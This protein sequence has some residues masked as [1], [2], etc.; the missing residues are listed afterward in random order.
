MYFHRGDHISTQ[1]FHDNECHRDF[2]HVHGLKDGM[3]LFSDAPYF[4]TKDNG[5]MTTIDR[6]FEQLYLFDSSNVLVASFELEF[7][8]TCPKHTGSIQNSIMQHQRKDIDVFLLSTLFV[9]LLF[10]VYMFYR[11]SYEN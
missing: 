3:Y 5:V 2:V 1:I 8:T 4:L 10:V 7:V 6:S 11:R 9:I